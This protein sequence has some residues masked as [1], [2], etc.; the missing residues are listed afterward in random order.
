MRFL[1]NLEKY[2]IWNSNYDTILLTWQRAKL[3]FFIL[4]WS[5]NWI[6]NIRM[7]ELH[8]NVCGWPLT[9]RPLELQ[10]YTEYSTKSNWKNNI[11]IYIWSNQFSLLCLTSRSGEKMK[12]DWAVFFKHW[13]QLFVIFETFRN[14]VNNQ[15]QKKANANCLLRKYMNP[16]EPREHNKIKETYWKKKLWRIFPLFKNKQKVKL[17]GWIE[18]NGYWYTTRLLLQ[19]RQNWSSNLMCKIYFGFRHLIQLLRPL[20]DVTIQQ[21]RIL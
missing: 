3:M 7:R 21:E 14:E 15:D 2:C 13:C 9:K 11:Y 1:K 16:Q 12:S 10:R 18:S 6:H 8:E 17:I 4:F 20:F 5:F 19:F